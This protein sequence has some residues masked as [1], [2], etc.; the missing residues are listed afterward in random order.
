ML[1]NCLLTDKTILPQVAP[2]WSKTKQARDRCQGSG[3]SEVAYLC[4]SVPTTVLVSASNY[5]RLKMAYEAM[6]KILGATITVKQLYILPKYLDTER[7]ETLMAVGKEHEVPL[8][9]QVSFPLSSYRTKA[10]MT[11]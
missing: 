11:V 10:Y 3:V 9:M 6:A 5:G 4:T 1:E 8:H 7:M 2:S